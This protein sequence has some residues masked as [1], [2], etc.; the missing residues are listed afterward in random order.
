MSDVRSHRSVPPS[1]YLEAF[2]RIGQRFLENREAYYNAPPTT[3]LMVVRIDPA[4]GKR[5]ITVMKWGLVPWFS[6]TGKMEYSTFNASAK[7]SR[8]RHRFESPSK[9]G[10]VPADLYYEWKKLGPTPKD[11]KQ[12]YA[13]PR[14]YGTPLLFAGLWDAWKSPEGNRL[15]SFTVITTAPVAGSKMSELHHRIPV[16]LAVSRRVILCCAELG[17][18]AY[19]A[20]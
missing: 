17:T 3:D 6:K 11:G 12:P 5:S 14:A 18:I 2:F 19:G 15:L 16:V 20:R 8:R 1:A 13:V 7:A 4:T 10:V 9:R